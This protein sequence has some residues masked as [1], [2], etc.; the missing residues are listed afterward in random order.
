MLQSQLFVQN[1]RLNQAATNSLPIRRGE[2]DTAAVALLQQAL[3]DL[4]I[5]T[6]RRSINADETLDG[7]CAGETLQPCGN[8]KK[9]TG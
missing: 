6:R 8:F 2:R 9:T 3:R 7:G 5:A 1:G 4:Q